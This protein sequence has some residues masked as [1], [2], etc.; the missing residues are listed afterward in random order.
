MIKKVVETVNNY[1][2]IAEAM[3]QKHMTN[4]QK[5]NKDYAGE[6]L[7]REVSAEDERYI[8]ELGEV[9]ENSLALVNIACDNLAAYVRGKMADVD[10]TAINEIMALKNTGLSLS[11]EELQ[12]FLDKYSL[13]GNYWAMRYMIDLCR[14]QGH[15]DDMHDFTLSDNLA[16][17]E[18]VRTDALFL[19]GNFESDSAEMQDAVVKI[20][21]GRIGA[22]PEAHFL[23][24]EQKF[25]SNPVC[26]VS[27]YV[28][29]VRAN[30]LKRYNELPCGDYKG[31]ANLGNEIVKNLWGEYIDGIH[32]LERAVSM[33]EK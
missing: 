27:G 11:D 12:I 18:Q 22:N 25:N 5:I 19:I 13:S 31:K 20:A 21:I 32:Q 1:K 28:A 17:V 24:Y 3:Y 8:A 9:R 16:L 23:E 15:K 4:T 30:L 7:Q 26:T 33:A 6:R 10:V 2:T 29:D 14:Q